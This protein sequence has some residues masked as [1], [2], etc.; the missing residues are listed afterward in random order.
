[1]KA[2]Q[3]P[4]YL[5]GFSSLTDGGAGI[6]F[7]TNELSAEDFAALK[8]YQ[9]QFGYLLFKANEFSASDIPHDQADENTKRPS[10]RLRAVLFLQAKQKGLDF[11]SYYKNRMEKII[12]Q[13]KLELE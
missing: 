2:I 13:E 9:N 10:Q 12:E 11:D 1:M 4:A 8:L 6:R 7:A 3:L 5:K